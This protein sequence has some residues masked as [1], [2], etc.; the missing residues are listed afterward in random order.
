MTGVKISPRQLLALLLKKIG[1]EHPIVGMNV[2]KIII[3]N[4]DNDIVSHAVP[5][6]EIDFVDNGSRF[7][8]DEC[9]LDMLC[10][11]A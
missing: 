6:N 2:S 3:L 10:C 11:V 5:V 8:C 1:L 7:V 9:T 4:A